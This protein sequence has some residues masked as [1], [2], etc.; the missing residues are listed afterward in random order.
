MKLS[1]E[2]V[3]ATVT[4]LY[5]TLLTLPRKL[6]EQLKEHFSQLQLD[7]SVREISAILSGKTL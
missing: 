4:K 6:R 2:S 5:T 3:E 1:R 7:R